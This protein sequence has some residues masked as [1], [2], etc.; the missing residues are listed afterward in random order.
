MFFPVQFPSWLLAWDTISRHRSAAV[1][2][3]ASPTT[4]KVGAHCLA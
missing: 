1:Q 3:S 4:I 2:L